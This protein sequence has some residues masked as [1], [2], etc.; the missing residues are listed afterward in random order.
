MLSSKSRILFLLAIILS[1]SLGIRLFLLHSRGFEL[2][3]SDHAVIGL[4]A[5]HILEGHWMIYYYG[6]GYMG[7][8]EAFV[9][10][11]FI[12]FIGSVPIAVQM[13]PLVFFIFF[14]TL[15]FFFLKKTVG[16]LESFLANLW[17]AAGS[18]DLARLSVT[19]LGGYPET[20]FFGVLVTGLALRIFTHKNPNTH[21]FLLGF[22]TGL[23]FW[24]NSLLLLMLVPLGFYLLLTSDFWKSL[25][26]QLTLGR[27]FFLRHFALPPL[28]R[29]VGI[30]INLWILFFIL[31]NIL[32]FLFGPGSLSLGNLSW[33]LPDP[34]FLVKKVKPL[35]WTLCGEV[36]VLFFLLGQWKRLQSAFKTYGPLIGGLI[37]GA[38][39]AI[40]YSLLD[41]GG[42]RMIHGSGIIY[43]RN[44][45]THGTYVLIQSF[46]ET[47]LGLSSSGFNFRISDGARFFYGLLWMGILLRAFWR[48]RS[49]ILEV[50]KL[51]P[52]E[53][54]PGILSL[55]YLFFALSVCLFNQ[56]ESA[57]YLSPLYFS[58][59]WLIALEAA[60][61]KK[62]RGAVC[63]FMLLGLM[64]WPSLQ[65]QNLGKMIPS[66]KTLQSDY[67]ALRQKLLSKDIRGGYADYWLSYLLTFLTKETIIIAPYHSQDRYPAYTQYVDQLS[68]VAYLFT[69]KKAAE[70]FELR[71]KEA[72]FFYEA[73]H[74]DTLNYVFIDRSKGS[75]KNIIQ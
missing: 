10:A 64:A 71:L 27:I 12:K 52:L 55:L 73:E 68:K 30:F 42:Y 41:L 66:Q 9:A 47:I 18:F 45:L 60:S 49:S 1:L 74:S 35:L 62:F 56:L 40:F 70:A 32:A 3:N 24:V 50:L 21:F 58:L 33:H 17:L 11:L 7:S 54:S 57:R 19:P 53:S 26:P 48:N 39:P 16:L 25:R 23:G 6:Q 46:W 13:A 4:M 5:R 31:K 37:L 59:A 36:F 61:W 69:Q 72:G 34:P 15:N 22:F 28:L 8:L 65:W 63:T 20:L 51:R 2:F 43:A 67:A 38:S 29:W 75:E 14:I 44:F